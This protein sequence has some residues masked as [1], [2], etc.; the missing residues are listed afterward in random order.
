MK[1]GQKLNSQLAV[2]IQ[3]PLPYEKTLLKLNNKWRNANFKK[4]D[5]SKPLK[6]TAVKILST[7]KD[8]A[9]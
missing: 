7:D 5:L 2:K 3:R 6:V 4:Q 1:N 8:V 9:K